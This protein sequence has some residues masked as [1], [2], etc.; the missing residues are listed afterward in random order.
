M[1]IKISII[2]NGFEEKVLENASIKD[3][4]QHFKEGDT[5]LIV[6]YNGR[7]VYP[8]Q[9]TEIIVQDGDRFEFINPNFGG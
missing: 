5:D 9:Y 4:I 2:V 8:A 6:E 3:L 7:F 1:A